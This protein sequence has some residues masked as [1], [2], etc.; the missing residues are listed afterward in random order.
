MGGPNEQ[1]LGASHA[2]VSV[3]VFRAA[4][5]PTTAPPPPV[6]QAL[7]G[8][9]L[10]DAGSALIPLTPVMREG[11]TRFFLAKFI[12]STSLFRKGEN[13]LVRVYPNL[14]VVLST[15]IVLCTSNAHIVS[16]IVFLGVP[17]KLLT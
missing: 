5:A 11:S 10:R 13:V 17:R 1:F 7:L 14:F 4:S 3:S 8:S 6:A 16:K 15:R 2:E 9:H 12:F